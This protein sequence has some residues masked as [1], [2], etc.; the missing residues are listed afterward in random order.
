MTLVQAI[1]LGVEFVTLREWNP[2]AMIELPKLGA[3]GEIPP[4]GTLYDVNYK[5][6]VLLLMLGGGDNWIEI[7]PKY[8]NQIKEMKRE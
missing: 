1:K 6:R 4:W 5:E 8:G 2:H 7:H 3:Q